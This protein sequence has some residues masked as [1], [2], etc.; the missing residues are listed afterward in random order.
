MKRFP[1]CPHAL[2]HKSSLSLTMAAVSSSPLCA[3]LH[4]FHETLEEQSQLLAALPKSPKWVRTMATLSSRNPSSAPAQSGPVPPHGAKFLRPPCPLQ[5]D[6]VLAVHTV[7]QCRDISLWHSLHIFGQLIDRIGRP[8]P[9]RTSSGLHPRLLGMFT[10]FHVKLQICHPLQAALH[11][12]HRGA[13]IQAAM[14]PTT[15]SSLPVAHNN[16]FQ[17]PWLP[18][19]RIPVSLHGLVLIHKSMSQTEISPG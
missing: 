19:G 3:E 8:L 11:D 15:F 7:H 13:R 16:L 14:R 17:Y 10:F 4:P 6:S 1:L 18:Y 2:G 9:S 12:A 5:Q